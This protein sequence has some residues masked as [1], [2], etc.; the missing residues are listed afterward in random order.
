MQSSRVQLLGLLETRGQKVIRMEPRASN[1]R[2]SNSFAYVSL[3]CVFMFWVFFALSVLP[4][5]LQLKIPM[6]EWLRRQPGWEWAI[7]E[8]F[9]L[10]LALIATV[11]GI[12]VG[13]KMW[14]IALPVSLLMFLLIMYA[15]GT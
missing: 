2:L 3:T 8:A 14:R 15:M 10:L 11:L 6:W 13:G 4:Q 1:G 12:F 5:H 7:L 9:A